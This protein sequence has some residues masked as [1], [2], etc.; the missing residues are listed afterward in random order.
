MF[1]EK[2]TYEFVSILVITNTEIWLD[3]AGGIYLIW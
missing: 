3:Q 1:T 2:H